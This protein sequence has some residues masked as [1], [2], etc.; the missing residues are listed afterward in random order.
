MQ[1]AFYVKHNKVQSYCQPVLDRNILKDYQREALSQKILS[2][3]EWIEVFV[4]ID[5]GSISDW[6]IV[7]AKDTT[8]LIE[9][10]TSE[11]IK[12]L[13]FKSLGILSPTKRDA[14]IFDFQTSLSFDSTDLV[15]P[16]RMRR[17]GVIWCLQP[18]LVAD[19]C[20]VNDNVSVLPSQMGSPMQSL[21]LYGWGFR[22]SC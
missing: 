12:I 19:L 17:I 3:T 20:I 2:L 1:D 18:S 6:L 11:E 15:F 7:I 14:A 16:L 21:H 13:S 8:M 9:E 5:S 22:K 10:D 4:G